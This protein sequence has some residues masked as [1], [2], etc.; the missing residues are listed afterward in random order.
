MDEVL[1]TNIFLVVTGTAI[2]IA[3]IVLTLVLLQVYRILRAV[4]RV[5]ERV[6]NGAVFVADEFVELR[7]ELM[8]STMVAKIIRSIIQ[9]GIS[10]VMDS[11]EETPKP[12]K[13]STRKR[14]TKKEA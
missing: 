7:K 3:T 9:L 12:K 11:M 6:S 2:V 13:R 4:R 14:T 5:V 8:S 1:I 10:N